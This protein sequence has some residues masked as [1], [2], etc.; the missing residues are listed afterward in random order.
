MEAAVRAL[1][2]M[3]VGAVVMA[4]P[5]APSDTL[6]SLSDEVDRVVCLLVP[7]NFRSVGQ[8]YLDFSQTTD[9]EVRSLLGF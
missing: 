7:D 2:R 6:Q 9:A 3:K 8:Y 1:R 5:V 4:V